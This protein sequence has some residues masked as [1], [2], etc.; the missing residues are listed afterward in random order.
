LFA[1]RPLFFVA[2][3]SAKDVPFSPKS[4]E[5]AERSTPMLQS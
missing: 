3:Y 4:V 5:P 1:E 2:G